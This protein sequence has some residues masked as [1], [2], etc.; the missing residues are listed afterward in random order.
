[1]SH[2]HEARGPRPSLPQA[3]L[4]GWRRPQVWRKCLEN[5][6]SLRRLLLTH[7][8]QLDEMPTPS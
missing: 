5:L 1:M 6:L 8:G 2:D 3:V 7:V 4:N